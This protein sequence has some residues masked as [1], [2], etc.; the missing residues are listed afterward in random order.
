V[1]LPNDDV[2][3]LLRERFVLG[4]R[5]IERDLHVGMSHGYKSNQE[6]V[7]TTNGAGGRNVQILVLTADE[8]VLH[9]LPGFWHAEDLLP[10]LRLAL[11][12]FRLHHDEGLD[13]AQRRLRFRSLHRSHVAMHGPAAIERGDWQSFDR[14]FEV[15]RART[16]ARDTVALAGEEAIELK[17]IPQLVHDRM[18]ARPFRKLAEFDLETFV[19]YGRPRYDN[20]PGKGR[21][22]PKAEAANAKREKAAAK[23]NSEEAK[24]EA[25]AARAGK[26]A[27]AAPGRW[28]SSN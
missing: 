4:N 22:F 2:M 27:T 21:E 16:E 7:G 28:T 11:E 3:Q 24:A 13:E 1:T 25:A 8:V 18:I 9:A 10:E 23:A 5:N 6:A 20:N 26:A 17:S 12:V 15:E 14:S 19:D